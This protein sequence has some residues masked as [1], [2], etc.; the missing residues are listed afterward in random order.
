MDRTQI[1]ERGFISPADESCRLLCIPDFFYKYKVRFLPP[2]VCDSELKKNATVCCVG[3]DSL[4]AEIFHIKRKHCVWQSV[5]LESEI[6]HG[7]RARAN[8]HIKKHARAFAVSADC[9][10]I[11]VCVPEMCASAALLKRVKAQ[12]KSA[13]E[14]KILG[15]QICI[16]GS[17]F[18]LV[19]KWK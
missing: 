8:I 15:C 7:A 2:F 12:M 9:L 18:S 10:L 1:Y 11:L 16:A 19:E 4:A 5:S 13:W 14:Q 17:V 6:K 3:F